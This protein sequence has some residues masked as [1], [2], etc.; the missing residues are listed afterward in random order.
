MSSTLLIQFT[1]TLSV[2]SSQYQVSQT[3]TNQTYNIDLEI[4]RLTQI[5]DT[6]I[7]LYNLL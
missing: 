3:P 1:P 6:L 5:Q 7:K 4:Y 2:E